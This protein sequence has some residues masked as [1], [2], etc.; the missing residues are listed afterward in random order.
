MSFLFSPHAPLSLQYYPN[1]TGAGRGGREL[2]CPRSTA[3]LDG[4]VGLRATTDACGLQGLQVAYL[5]IVTV[6]QGR[7]SSY[8]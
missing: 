3:E 2:V 6:L 7:I 8:R 5:Y 1:T 4:G